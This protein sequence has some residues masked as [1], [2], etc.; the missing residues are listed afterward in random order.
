MRGW[1]VMGVGAVLLA[2]CGSSGSGAKS[3]ASESTAA[4]TSV[5]TTVAVEATQPSGTTA[6]ATSAPPTTDKPECTNGSQET[7][8]QTDKSYDLYRCVKGKWTF[9]Q[10]VAVT[11]TTLPPTTTLAPPQ[12]YQ[13]KGDDVVDIGPG[14]TRIILHATHDGRSNFIVHALDS[15][16]NTVDG[17]VNE[18]G[19]FN[20]VMFLNESGS[21]QDVRY[22]EVQADGNWLLEL[23]DVSALPVVGDSFTGV[24]QQIVV[25]NGAGGI[26]HVTHDG[27][28]NFIVHVITRDNADGIINEIGPYDG[29]QAMPAG[30]AFVAVRADGNWTFTKA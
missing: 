16:L 6:P 27:Q 12:V 18:I 29:R 22:L 3:V 15:S 26:F 9:Y 20:G 25:Y 10:T 7:R 11:T 13:G 14:N 4:K 30:P 8:N 17:L 19:A 1:V 21:A 23:V 28:S 24:G 5:Q 2:A